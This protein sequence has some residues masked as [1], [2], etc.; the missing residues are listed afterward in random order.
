MLWLRLQLAAAV[1]V[2]LWLRRCFIVSIN[3]VRRMAL[4]PTHHTHLLSSLFQAG[5]NLISTGPCASKARVLESPRFLPRTQVA[6]GKRISH[7][8]TVSQNLLSVLVACSWGGCYNEADGS[9]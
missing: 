6:S 9:A 5:W 8:L 1:P 2:L 4:T 7:S 3:K